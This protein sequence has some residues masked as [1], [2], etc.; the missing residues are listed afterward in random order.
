[1]THKKK[2]EKLLKKRTK[3]EN[4]LDHIDKIADSEKNEAFKQKLEN[5]LKSRIKRNYRSLTENLEVKP[6]KFIN[7]NQVYFD[8]RFKNWEPRTQKPIYAIKNRHKRSLTNGINSLE[9]EIEDITNDFEKNMKFIHP[10]IDNGKM[11]LILPNNDELKIE[12]REIKLILN[13]ITIKIKL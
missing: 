5:I 11:E 13:F 9:N 3:E 7:Q 10:K 8:S 2:L 4:F 12:K 1:M 6:N